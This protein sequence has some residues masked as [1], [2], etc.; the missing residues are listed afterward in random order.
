MRM[1]VPCLVLLSGS[2]SGIAVSCCVGRR[3]GSEPA[4][5]CHGVSQGCS[6]DLTPSLV[7]SMY[8]ECGPKKQS[9]RKEGK[10]GRK[11]ETEKERKKEK[12]RERK[13]KK[14]RKEVRETI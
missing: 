3:C 14:E 12:E 9:K 8:S 6:S 2:G 5:L 10:K 4:L 1:W 13:K 11:E 7:T